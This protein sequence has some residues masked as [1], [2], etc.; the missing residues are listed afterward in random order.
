MRNNSRFISK[1]DVLSPFS[2]HELPKVEFRDSQTPSYKRTPP[3]VFVLIPSQF[4]TQNIIWKE[5][6]NFIG[7]TSRK[8]VLHIA[9]PLTVYTVF[10]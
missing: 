6:F 5:L 4:L 7:F 2:I 8:L 9:K 3:H 1:V 10:S